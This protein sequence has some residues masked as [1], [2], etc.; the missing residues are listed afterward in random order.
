MSALSC[1]CLC[2]VALHIT[3]SIS[4]ILKFDY[5]GM[6]EIITSGGRQSYA[7]A[8]VSVHM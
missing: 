6:S 2:A 5:T 3:K 7:C 1:L 4:V 8:E